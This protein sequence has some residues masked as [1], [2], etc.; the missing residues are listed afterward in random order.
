[1]NSIITGIS[2]ISHLIENPES[3]LIGEFHH[4]AVADCISVRNT[5]GAG[6]HGEIHGTGSVVNTEPKDTAY[7]IRQPTAAL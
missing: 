6:I 1:M 4:A 3:C 7:C 5:G 2:E